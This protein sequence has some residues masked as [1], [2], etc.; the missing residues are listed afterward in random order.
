MNKFVENNFLVLY[1]LF[2]L[3]FSDTIFRGY[4]NEH[5]FILDFVISFLI[6]LTVAFLLTFICSFFR[7]ST[8]YLLSVLLLGII[9]FIYSSQLIYFKFFKTFYSFYS[10]GNGAQAFE[11][12]KDIA[13]L[14]LINSIWIL[15][16]FFPMF[17]LIAI[18]KKRLT[19]EVPTWTRRI[20]LISC[21]LL[22]QLTGI[23]AVY[24]SGKEMNSAY[25]LYYKSSSLLLSVERLG[26]LT[27]MRLDL[28][29]LVFD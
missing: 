8:S 21:V 2:S 14:M 9:A 27:T 24:A 1:F 15:L 29:R 6:L 17:F 23:G 19:V 13:K 11:F 4:I 25:N 28:Q 5:H 16:F 7:S 10:V 26:L 22:A 18:G 3:L 20:V 12:W